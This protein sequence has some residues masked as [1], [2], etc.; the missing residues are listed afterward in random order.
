MA[1]GRAGGTGRVGRSLNQCRLKTYLDA[2]LQELGGHRAGR[3]Q[4]WAATELER[5]QTRCT[6][7]KAW[8]APGLARMPT[9]GLGNS[10]ALSTPTG[11]HFAEH[12]WGE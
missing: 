3:P 10:R 7:S 9:R 11:V 4:S 8:W 2:Q 5:Q 1:S 6:P 12:R